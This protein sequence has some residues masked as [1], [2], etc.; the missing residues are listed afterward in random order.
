MTLPNIQIFDAPALSVH[1]STSA[2]H[3]EHTMDT[4]VPPELPSPVPSYSPSKSVRTPPASSP[5]APSASQHPS[6]DKRSPS[7]VSF[8]TTETLTGRETPES[9]DP[10]CDTVFGGPI[11]ADPESITASPEA[12]GENV[13]TG[14][15]T[16]QKLYLSP[17]PISLFTEGDHGRYK[18]KPM[19]VHT[20]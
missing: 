16:R 13:A 8:S 6:S 17:S 7:R 4:F 3:E 5:V 15:P 1:S 12:S 11:T 2:V 9:T 18:R 14:I 20:L 10:L 19:Y